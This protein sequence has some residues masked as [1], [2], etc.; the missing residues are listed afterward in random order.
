MPQ[1][2]QQ[3]NGNAQPPSAP[4]QMVKAES[5]TMLAFEEACQ[6]GQR[7]M[8]AFHKIN[9]DNANVFAALIETARQ[10]ILALDAREAELTKREAAVASVRAERDKMALHN[11]DLREEAT[12]REAK[13]DQYRKS[14]SD[15]HAEN[16][17]LQKQIEILKPPKQIEIPV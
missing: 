8:F 17:R 3:Q 10:R 11:K 6:Q 1:P 9:A 2:A 15:L 14:I 13:I 16:L 7:A 5:V 4:E 12:K